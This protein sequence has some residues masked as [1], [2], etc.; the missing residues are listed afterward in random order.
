MENRIDWQISTFV[1]NLILYMVIVCHVIYI[2][3]HNDYNSVQGVKT[4]LKHVTH[5]TYSLLMQREIPK[6]FSGKL[7]TLIYPCTAHT[8]LCVIIISNMHCKF[9]IFIII[10]FNTIDITFFFLFLKHISCFFKL[11]ID[12]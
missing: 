6:I 12:K 9:I 11:F 8:I 2:I 7:K 10:S 5:Q 1:S 3:I 4:K